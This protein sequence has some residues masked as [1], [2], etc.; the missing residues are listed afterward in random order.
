VDIY[1]GKVDGNYHSVKNELIN[2]QVN[3]NIIPNKHHDSA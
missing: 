2:Y 1:N 3:E